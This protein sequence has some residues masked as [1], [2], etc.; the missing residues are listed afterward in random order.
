MTE[1]YFEKVYG[2]EYY[3]FDSETITKEELE[4]AIDYIGYTAFENSLTSKEIINLLNKQV[5]NCEQC[6]HFNPLID[7]AEGNFYQCMRGNKM[8][9]KCKD[10]EE[11]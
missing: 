11:I 5:N 9:E 1:R 6:Y 10:Y 7:W 2:E 8:W 3:I 4:K